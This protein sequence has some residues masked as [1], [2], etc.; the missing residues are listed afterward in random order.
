VIA[1]DRIGD[2]GPR[3]QI[4]ASGSVIS[5]DRIG[6][7]GPRVQ[8]T[9]TGSVIADDRIGDSGPRVWSLEGNRSRVAQHSQIGSPILACPVLNDPPVIADPGPH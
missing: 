3:V 8:I 4:T 5:D 9:A 2:N 7:S 6:D 1:D